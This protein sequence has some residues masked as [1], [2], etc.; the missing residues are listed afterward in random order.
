MNIQIIPQAKNLIDSV[1]S[2][3]ALLMLAGFT[4][5]TACA[6][7][8]PSG[9]AAAPAKAKP[10]ANRAPSTDL[11]PGVTQ[12]PTQ[13][14]SG[15]DAQGRSYKRSGVGTWTNYDES[16]A[17]PYPLPDPLVLKNGQ[18]VKDADTWWKQRRPE[19]LKDFQT[20]IYGRI[21][22]T[23]KVTW[24]VTATDTSAARGA[25][26][27]KSI[28]G[29]IDNSHYTSAHPSINITLY[30]P[31]K[32]AGPAPVIVSVVAGAGGYGAPRA[33]TQAKSAPQPTPPPGSPLYQLLAIGWGYATMEV[34]PIQNDYAGGL[35]SGII[36]L[37][38][39]GKPR[40][41]DDWGALAAWAWGLSRAIDYFETDKAVD[42]K[43]LG[44]EG[45]SR[46]GKAALLAAALDERWAIAYPSCSGEG[47][48]KL[49]RRNWGETVDNIASS[50]WMAANF[51]KY[52]GHWGD[53]PVDSHE[54]IALV[55]PR[56]VFLNGGTQDQWADPHGAFLAAVAAGPVY[57]LLGKKD[58]GATE[59]P[60][61]DTALV[62]GELAF[63]YHAGGHTDAIDFP[64]FLQFAQ[65]YLKA[66]GG[67]TKSK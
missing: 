49:S 18:A 38:A 53:L 19:I 15:T 54:L 37:V 29:H 26:V 65:R 51:R 27:M 36:G 31:S 33:G 60:S 35:T 3:I 43:Q 34:G 21:P 5:G 48:A 55:A 47:G 59:M 66:P 64:A 22:E 42:A 7:A 4:A 6:Q 1:V 40:Q 50:H 46:Y 39:E 2:G 25:A 67:E 56:P 45:H 62:S 61:P 57:R 58:L 14:N 24:E 16:K 41:P 30:T 10:D 9:T 11:P 44:V 32:A 20:E 8:T 52:A 12:N 17:N 23:P 28:V 63:R 13:P